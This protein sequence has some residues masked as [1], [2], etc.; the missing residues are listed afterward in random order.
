MAE[1]CNVVQVHL[2]KAVPS[3]LYDQLR[4]TRVLNPGNSM[5][6]I[7][8]PGTEHDTAHLKT[9][10]VVVVDVASVVKCQNHRRFIRGNRLN[11]RSLGGFWR[12]TTERFFAIESF[13]EACR[14]R[15]VVHME[16]DVM[17]YA[18]LDSL[19]PGFHAACPGAGIIMDSER[20]CVPGLMY[21]SALPA[22]S[23]MNDFIVRNALRKR[24]T[25]M[26]AIGAF[27]GQATFA[28]CSALPVLPPR[29]RELFPLVNAKA[30]E[31]SSPWYDAAFG[32][33]GGVFDGAALGQFV[34]GID[35]IHDPGDTTG[36]V[37]ETAVYDPRKMGI[38]WKTENG[39]RRPFGMVDGSEFP[40]FNLH[41]HSKQLERFSSSASAPTAAPA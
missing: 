4:Q 22:L 41:I 12:Y 32:Q 25:D 24:Q 17:L 34:G 38:H 10:E 39:L 14:L 11:P 9:L 26:Q 37:N 21:L 29:Y 40:I 31:G 5:Y 36:F 23:A 2:G 7:L 13:L 30:E 1:H 8:G 16:N 19:L 28:E 18:G 33:F 15:N 20:R 27:M 35:K 3:Y 6:L